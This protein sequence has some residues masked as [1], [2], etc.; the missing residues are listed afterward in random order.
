[1]GS[2][3]HLLKV[4]VIEVDRGLGRA[5]VSRQSAQ[6]DLFFVQDDEKN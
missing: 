3:A 1:M 2:I 5:M 6:P 4:D